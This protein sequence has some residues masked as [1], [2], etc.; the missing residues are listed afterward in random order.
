M[1]Q[2][3]LRYAADAV[4]NKNLTTKSLRCREEEEEAVEPLVWAMPDTP[5]A[6]SK[7]MKQIKF[8]PDWFSD[9]E[10]NVWFVDIKGVLG[11]TGGVAPVHRYL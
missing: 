3:H 6:R 7:T 4:M 1:C 9:P 10:A 8:L 2:K 11:L 5:S